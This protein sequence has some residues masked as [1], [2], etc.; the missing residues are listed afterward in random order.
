MKKYWTKKDND[1]I[2]TK[3]ATNIKVCK[4]L[5]LTRKDN[6]L[7][8]DSLWISLLTKKYKIKEFKKILLSTKNSY[9]LEYDRSAKEII[10]YE[11]G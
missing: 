9:L 4:K 3:I 6:F 1:G 7:S 2:I 5:G 8:T 11:V 10:R